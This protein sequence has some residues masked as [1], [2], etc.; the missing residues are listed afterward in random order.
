MPRSPGIAE[1]DD[2]PVD[3][4]SL[5]SDRPTETGLKAAPRTAT[6]SNPWTDE[7]A[8]GDDLDGPTT[9]TMSGPG[10]VSSEEPVNTQKLPRTGSNPALPPTESITRPPLPSVH[11][12]GEFTRPL[13]IEDPRAGAQAHGTS[14][15]RPAFT[16]VAA[17]PIATPQS[18]PSYGP[19]PPPP[20]DLRP[21][22]IPP[23]PLAPS[24]QTPR[25]GFPPP[26]QQ[27][28][29]ARRSEPSPIIVVAAVAAAVI[30][31][32]LWIGGC[33]LIRGF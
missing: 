12:D 4:E 15:T 22:F 28:Q 8:P 32:G 27:A 23:A 19:P 5:D 25:T 31:L 24:W 14:A 9:S 20:H 18:I 13:T 21:S 2:A 33:L 29:Q 6:K 30:I 11:P 1:V 16:P 17:Q 10:P 7:L 3:S 26:M